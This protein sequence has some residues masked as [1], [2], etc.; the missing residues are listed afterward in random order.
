MDFRTIENGKMPLQ[1]TPLDVNHMVNAIA[2]DFRN[3]AL[4]KEMTFEVKCDELPIPIHA[5]KH[6]LEKIL[7]NLLN[8][9][10]K[11]TRQG[12]HISIE[13]YN[14]VESFRSSHANHFTVQGDVIP[15]DAFL[16]VVRDTGIGISKDS[17][18]S[19]FERFYKV[20]TDQADTH[21]GTGIGLALVKS[22]VLLHKGVL[23]IYSERESG[24]DIVVA[25]SKSNHF[26]ALEDRKTEEADS[27]VAI[28]ELDESSEKLLSEKKHILLVEDNDD[29]RGLIAESLAA[30]YEVTEAANGALA[31]EAL[32]K[33]PFDLVIS[34]IMM[35]VKDGIT[36]CR[37]VKNDINLS[38]IPFVLLTAKTGLE[39]KL[40]GVDSGAD[41]YFEKPVDSKLLRASVQNIF[42]TRRKLQEYYA[43][44]YFADTSELAGSRQDREFLKQF[45]A[46]VEK[47]ID[48]S[49][50]DV[51]YIASE[52]SISRSKLYNKVKSLTNKSIVEFILQYRLRK[53]ARLLVEEDMS[54]REIMEQVGIESQSYFTAT[55]KKEFDETPTAF[56]KRHAEKRKK[57][58]Q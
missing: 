19:V 7:L 36:L 54:I 28:T 55:F 40:E 46:V 26:Y 34:D 18:A 3:Y 2:Y 42:N 32:R 27:P 16:I 5:D 35:P 12:G 41:L 38:H 20:N 21:L 29:L 22:L 14:D 10:F 6:I 44:N 13:T 9:A 43:K 58:N 15:E 31:A 51:N 1:V 24:T 52:L 17:I 37:E 47:N 53:A 56:A 50:M 33:E 57:G 25:L 23:T 49:E 39:S 45:I 11:Y 8:N 30:D 4:Q 48:Q